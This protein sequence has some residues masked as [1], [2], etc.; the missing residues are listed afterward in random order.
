MTTPTQSLLHSILLV[1]VV[2]VALGTVASRK[3]FNQEF[4]PF[5]SD[6]PTTPPST[7]PN[8]FAIPLEPATALAQARRFL[9]A[10][11]PDQAASVLAPALG[12]SDPT[13]RLQARLLLA[14]AALAREEPERA[15]E[16]CLEIVQRAPKS[17]EAGAAVV[18]A[19]QAA[20]AVGQPG[21]AA[22]QWLAARAL[23]PDLAPYLAYL[24]LDA[25]TQAGEEQ[26][27]EILVEQIV[28]TAPVRRLAVAALEW[29]QKH[30][31]QS[32][33]DQ[34]AL[35]TIDRLLG[36]AT[37]PNYRAAL[38]FERA[39]VAERLGDRASAKANL[40]EVLAIAPDSH[41]AAQ[42]LDLLD[43]WG[44]G[45]EVNPEQRLRA[46]LTSGRYQE[47]VSTATAMLNQDPTRADIWYRRAFAR[48]RAG[49][50]QGGIQDF[51]ALADRYPEKAQTPS[52]L[53]TAGELLEWEDL[54]RAAETYRR[55]LALYPAS[56]AA[57]EAQF[58]LGLLAYAAGDLEGA[59]ANWQTLADHDARA[60][61]WVGK[62]RA[63]QGDLPAAREAW[64]KAQ[65]LDPHGFYG[66][67]AR[68]SLTGTS[69]ISTPIEPISLPSL[70]REP[71]EEWLK[72]RGESWEQASTRLVTSGAT[73][74]VLFLLELGRR[75]EAGWELAA[76]Q[77]ELRSDPAAL[78][79]L[80]WLLLER[81][82]AAFAYQIATN[83]A[84]QGVVPFAVLAPFL[85]P[86]PYPEALLQSAQRFSLDPLLVAALIRQES[87]FE[88][89]ALSPAGAR[90]L[91][92]VLPSTAA[93]IVHEL[94]IAK[95]N[96]DSLFTPAT[97]LLLG[98]A[99]LARRLTQYHGQLFFTLA[100]YNAGDGAVQEWRTHWASDDPDLFVERIPYDETAAYV[101]SVYTNYRLYQALYQPSVTSVPFP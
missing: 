15:L 87:A 75:E 9:A 14:R 89:S 55:L 79:T 51:L 42:A 27:A 71:I 83:L 81:G 36:L 24:A 78:L 7:S 82:E 66:I 70:N 35:A 68:E 60:A 61:F 76:A 48:V 10:G 29:R 28:R 5:P 85:Y 92:Q 56:Q 3:D 91:T 12:A 98:S 65:R 6:H 46:Y 19:G 95:W 39:Q 20:L 1:L 13:F 32:G 77:D 74:R 63:D 2:S 23:L 80:G 16:L 97:S 18:L 54:R 47:A 8:Q 57:Q 58:R 62:A 94:G 67:R 99:E 11:L 53:F 73:Q 34:V 33:N 101:R 93:G 43:R 64:L 25:L 41:I 37:L 31:Q 72:Q 21:A 26:Q 59:L 50:I 88:P 17:P 40:L 45:D 52:A 69:P 22:G 4:A 49:D 86:V 38:L 90:G 96:P 30:A 100:G 44:A 84:N